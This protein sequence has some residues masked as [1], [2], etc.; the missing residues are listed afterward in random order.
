M[1]WEKRMG[2]SLSDSRWKNHFSTDL[3]AHGGE[4]VL[5]ALNRHRG[6]RF[7][8]GVLD[9]FGGQLPQKRRWIAR[10][11]LAVFLAASAMADRQALHRAR[12]GNVEQAAFLVERAVLFGPGMREQTVLQADD[13]N[14]G[15]LQSFAT[16]HSDQR[17]RITFFLCFLFALALECEFFQKGF[18][19]F[20]G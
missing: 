8:V 1:D 20:G 18:Q 7:L 13:V 17:D 5:A 19:T 15:K 2:V 3:S 12:D 6:L 14:V 9:E 11:D 4:K 10:R 16:V